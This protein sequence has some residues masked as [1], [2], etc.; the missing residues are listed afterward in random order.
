MPPLSKLNIWGIEKAGS[1]KKH[2]LRKKYQNND[3]D[4][5][6]LFKCSLINTMICC[7]PQLFYS[8]HGV[9]SNNLQNL[10]WYNHHN[11]LFNGTYFFDQVRF[12]SYVYQ[13]RGRRLNIKLCVRLCVKCTHSI[14]FCSIIKNVKL[15]L[16]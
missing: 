3:Q 16:K 2:I 5:K 14:F 11:I 15:F 12:E 10:R 8:Q 1:Q 6:S 4:F 13:L 7:R 9:V